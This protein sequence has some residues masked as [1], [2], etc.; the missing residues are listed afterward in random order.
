MELLKPSEVAEWTRLSEQTLANMRWQGRGPAY[1]KAGGRVV[2]RRSDVENWL[3]ST[4]SG[5]TS[6]AA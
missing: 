6:D 3:D 5:G 2:Y 4:A 1:L